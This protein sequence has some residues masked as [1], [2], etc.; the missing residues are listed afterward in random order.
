MGKQETYS[1]YKELSSLINETGLSENQKKLINTRIGGQLHFFDNKAVKARNRNFTLRLVG[2][3]ASILVPTLININ[4]PGKNQEQ[5]RDSILLTASGLSLAGAIAI[6]IHD[7]LKVGTEY[8]HYRKFCEEGKTICYRYLFLTDKYKKYPSHEAAFQDFTAQMEN[9]FRQETTE[10]VE[11]VLTPQQQEEEQDLEKEELIAQLHQATAQLSQAAAQ[12][13]SYQE[14]ESASSYNE[15]SDSTYPEYSNSNLWENDSQ[16]TFTATESPSLFPMNRE[17]AQNGK[18]LK[19]LT[20]SDIKALVASKG[21][22][23]TMDKAIVPSAVPS[24]SVSIAYS[25]NHL[26]APD[27]SSNSSA[28]KQ[29]CDAVLTVVPATMRKYATESVPLILS[30]CNNCGISDRAQIAYI[31]ATAEHESHLGQWMTEFASGSAYE[32]RRDLGNTQPGDGK[33]YKGRGYTQLTG[34]KN[35]QRW[36]DKISIDLVSNPEQAGQPQIAA[37]IMVQAMKEGSFTG[38]GLDKYVNDSKHDFRN[39][40]RIINGLDRADQIANIAQRYY[41]AIA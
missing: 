20:A 23:W 2:I 13:S 34:R 18:T 39:A 4:I 16:D 1:L 6:S 25:S 33:R 22:N 9:L 38:V 35:Y 21:T 3:I 37:R 29:I 36:S 27:N 11:T 5:L 19:Y 28:F 32:G 14:P 15:P 26:N 24:N 31:L 30:E 41:S 40:R 7:F 17:L 12:R 8:T 10:Y